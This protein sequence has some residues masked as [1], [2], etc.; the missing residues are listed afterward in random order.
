MMAAFRLHDEVS[1][2][3][4]DLQKIKDLR[5]NSALKYL[6]MTRALLYV[7]SSCVFFFLNSNGDCLT[8]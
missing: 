8:E 5:A 4:M 3:H 6:K 2:S 7:M 1:T